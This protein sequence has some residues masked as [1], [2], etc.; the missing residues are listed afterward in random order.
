MNQFDKYEDDDD[1]DF[2][3]DDEYDFEDDDDDDDDM[4]SN[5]NFSQSFGGDFSMAKKA[6]EFMLKQLN[7]KTITIK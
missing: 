7:I 4:P 6:E 2:E 3:D 5:K 1:Y